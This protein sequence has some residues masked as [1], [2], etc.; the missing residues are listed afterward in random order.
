MS[1]KG[2]QEE[3]VLAVFGGSGGCANSFTTLALQ[4]GFRVRALAR[5]PSRIYEML[6]S[7]NEISQKTLDEQ[8]VVIEGDATDREAVKRTLFV[9]NNNENESEFVSF[10]FFGIGGSPT[11]RFSLKNPVTL[12]NPWVCEKS[13]QAIID[14]LNEV[15]RAQAQ[16]SY[17]GPGLAIVSTTG[18]SDGPIDVPFGLRW[19]YRFLLFVPHE[20]KRRMESIVKSAAEENLFSYATTVRCSLLTGDHK[21]KEQSGDV[22]LKVGTSKN[23]TVGYTIPRTVVGGWMF[24]NIL[25]SSNQQQSGYSVIT[26]TT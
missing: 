16:S 15:Q 26:L 22:S 19:M 18:I 5:N 20:D 17:V 1:V 4:S 12:D 2:I 8:L 6:L 10:V 13:M 25:I 11:L 21:I 24:E 14:S 9:K 3:R 23:P 7:Q